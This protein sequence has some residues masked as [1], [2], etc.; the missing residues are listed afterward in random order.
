MAVSLTLLPSNP[1][2]RARVQSDEEKQE[3]KGDELYIVDIDGSIIDALTF[4]SS[5]TGRA[6]GTEGDI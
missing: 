5:G 6:E 2:V 3:E 4:K 1:A